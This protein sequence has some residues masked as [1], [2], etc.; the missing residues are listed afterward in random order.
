MAAMDLGVVEHLPEAGE[1]NA[2]TAVMDMATNKA[3]RNVGIIIFCRQS[4]VYFVINSQ[5]SECEEGLDRMQFQNII[6]KRMTLGITSPMA[7]S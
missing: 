3:R 7:D 2:D 1:A 6:V 4:V 5:G